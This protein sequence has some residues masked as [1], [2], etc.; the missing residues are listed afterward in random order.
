MNPIVCPAAL[1]YFIVASVGERYN[2]IYVYRQ[3]GLCGC[4]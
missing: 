2:F 3:V 1:A 4:V